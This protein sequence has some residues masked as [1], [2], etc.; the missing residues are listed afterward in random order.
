MTRSNLKD[1]ISYNIQQSAIS[2]LLHITRSRQKH[3]RLII[4]NV[5]I[6]HKSVHPKTKS[7][8]YPNN[9]FNGLETRRNS[10]CL[11]GKACFSTCS[12]H[13]RPR[14]KSLHQ[15]QTYLL[16]Y[17]VVQQPILSTVLLCVYKGTTIR[18]K[19]HF[20][21]SRNLSSR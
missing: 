1:I 15:S 17:M 21:R 10:G 11:Y 9:F 16:N 5:V 19:R 20:L 6:L 3:L 7:V 2:S 12:F 4:K 18:W 13:Q 8:L 14:T